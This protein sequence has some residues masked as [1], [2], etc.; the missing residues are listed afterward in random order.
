M[1]VLERLRHLMD[2]RGW[3]VYRVARESGL[4]EKTVYNIYSRNT[5]PS[6]PTLEAICNAFGITLA[7]FF[8][9]GKLIEMSLDLEEVF[10]NWI[11]LT[12]EQKEATLSMMRAFR[13]E[14]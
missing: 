6:I 1:D 9:D 4:S 7:Q 3:T 13:R 14:Q 8:A 10:E 12:P 5:M 2:E 11:V